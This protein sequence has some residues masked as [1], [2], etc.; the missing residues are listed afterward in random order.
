MIRTGAISRRKRSSE[1]IGDGGVE[2]VVGSEEEAEGRESGDKAGESGG[3]TRD[4]KEER[5]E[6]GTDR[7]ENSDGDSDDDSV[8]PHLANGYANSVKIRVSSI[9]LSDDEDTKN[10]EE[11]DDERM[12]EVTDSAIRRAFKEDESHQNAPLTAETKK[13]NEK[14]GCL[15][16]LKTDGA[17]GTF[18]THIAKLLMLFLTFSN[19]VTEGWLHTRLGSF[20][21]SLS[22][23]SSSYA[24][25]EG[26]DGSVL[27]DG[28]DGEKFAFPNQ[29]SLR[30][31]EVIDAIKTN[32]EIACPSMVSCADILTLAAR[33]AVFLTGGPYWAIALGRRDGLTA[34]QTAANTD[35][36]S[37]F[38]PLENITAKF[39]SK[40]LDRNDVVVLSG[41]HTIGFAQCFTFKPRLFNFDGS[42]NPDPTLDALLLSN[43]QSLCPN[44]DNS[45][46]NLAPLDRVSS[47]R[48]DNNYYNNLLNNSG[49]LESDQAL[50][51]DNRTAAMVNIYSKFP[52]L[53]SKNFGVSM[54]KMSYI[55][56]LTGQNGQIRK[57]CRVVN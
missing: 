23:L 26:C 9:D 31:F 42:G 35:L 3:A 57:N 34:N 46:T 52:F 44:Q 37:P 21:S 18:Y 47:S 39:T 55:G 14:L 29:N 12:F 1:M 8:F 54:V 10:N 40:G 38:D 33:E 11:D 24:C 51:G 13:R 48:F 43:L 22:A 2:D 28:T 6:E 36:P 56:V 15:S 53:F 16:G 45:D 7:V 30:G 17:P 25:F 50:M 4:A 49:L 41:A 20:P 32:V 5:L 19:F 27:L